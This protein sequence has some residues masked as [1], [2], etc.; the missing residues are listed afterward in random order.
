MKP[1][2]PLERPTNRTRKLSESQWIQ[3]VLSVKDLDISEPGDH[4]TFSR[5]QLKQAASKL[6]SG[7]ME[8]CHYLSA[9]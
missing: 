3:D 8:A 4:P 9:K 5:H 6:A 1:R 2:W 7:K